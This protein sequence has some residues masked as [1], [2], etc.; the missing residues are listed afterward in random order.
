MAEIRTHW[1]L[2]AASL[3]NAIAALEEFKA[4][5]QGIHHNP[6]LAAEFHTAFHTAKQTAAQAK[7]EKAAAKEKSSA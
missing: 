7:A 3:P 2:I 5:L 4:G 6:I 1:K